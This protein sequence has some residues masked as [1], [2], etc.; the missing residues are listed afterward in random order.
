MTGLEDHSPFLTVDALR[1]ADEEPAFSVQVFADRQARAS[2]Y[3]DAR[4]QRHE[5]YLV[6]QGNEMENQ[7]SSLT[8]QVESVTDGL[9][10]VANGGVA[11]TESSLTEW[12]ALDTRVALLLQ[13]IDEHQRR[14][15]RT[16][17]RLR[18]PLAVLTD[19]ETRFPQIRRGLP[20][21]S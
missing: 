19:L 4:V 18:D 17:V 2:A 21:F 16:V 12:A 1:V 10:A 6:S 20:D 8:Q 3:V 13:Q 15:E 7:A 5:G 9:L 11:D 14:V